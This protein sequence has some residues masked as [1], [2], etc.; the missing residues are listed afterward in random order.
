M[1]LGRGHELDCKVGRRRCVTAIFGQLESDERL[2]GTC[3]GGGPDRAVIQAASAALGQLVLYAP[4]LALF[5]GIDERRQDLGL[6]RQEVLIEAAEGILAV[7]SVAQ[8]D[9]Q[10]LLAPI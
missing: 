1:S 5:V 4:L 3:I 2:A 10:V 7:P 8:K 6:G 9:A